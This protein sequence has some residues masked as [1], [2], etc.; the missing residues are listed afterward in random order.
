LEEGSNGTLLEPTAVILIHV[1]FLPL[2]YFTT[3]WEIL[4]L[5]NEVCEKKKKKKV[6]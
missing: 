6:K 2:C 5:C 1:L 3:L 4:G